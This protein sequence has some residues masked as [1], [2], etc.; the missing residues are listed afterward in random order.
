MI[1]RQEPVPD[2]ECLNSDS[3]DRRAQSAVPRNEDDRYPLF[4][5]Y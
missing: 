1:R 2:S 5:I 4:V 3:Q